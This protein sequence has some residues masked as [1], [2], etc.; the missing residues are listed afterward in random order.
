MDEVW[1]RAALVAGALA[2][3]GVVVLVQRLRARPSVRTVGETSLAPGTYLFT[4]A[5]CAG[6]AQARQTLRTELGE[7]RFHEFAWE[8]GSAPFDELGIDAVPAV[9]VVDPGGRGTVFPGQPDRALRRI[10]AGFD[11]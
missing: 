8:E 3:A 1:A 11:P 9:L 4:S 10:V 2:V 5:T 7:D 6:C